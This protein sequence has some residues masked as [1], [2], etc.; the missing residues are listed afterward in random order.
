M[1]PVYRR[2]TEGLSRWTARR[3]LLLDAQSDGGI[4]MSPFLLTMDDLRARLLADTSFGSL[5][6]HCAMYRRTF[7]FEDFVT[8]EYEALG[9]GGCPEKQGWGDRFSPVPECRTPPTRRPR[10]RAT[11]RTRP[12]PQA[13]R[14]HGRHSGLG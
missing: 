9:G 11:R 14:D 13:R 4:R 1:H 10:A 7:R 6:E 2:F 12:L 5:E 3:L 8:A